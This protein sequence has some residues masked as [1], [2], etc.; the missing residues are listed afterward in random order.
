MHG[1]GKL[2][3]GEKF[4]RTLNK[5]VIKLITILVAGIICIPAANA[6][7]I[8]QQSM[9]IMQKGIEKVQL[10]FINNNTAVIKEGL[11]EVSKGNALFSKKHI[12][13]KYLPKDKNHM[14]NTAVNAAKRIHADT[15]IIEL[16]LDDK[17]YTKA[18]QGYA[19]MINACSRCHELIRNW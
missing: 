13:I 5:I 18:T 6:N 4:T 10:G 2:K 11:A 16:N 12:I 17:A 19:D 9:D 15:T 8:M 7:N 3:F 14:V 1:Y